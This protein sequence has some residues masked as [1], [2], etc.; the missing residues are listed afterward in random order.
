MSAQ[1]MSQGKVISYA[2]LA[3]F[4]AA[5]FVVLVKGILD[6]KPICAE[7]LRPVSAVNSSITN[8]RE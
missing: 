4:L 1:T 7:D 6:Y 3:V 8:L 2:V 5:T